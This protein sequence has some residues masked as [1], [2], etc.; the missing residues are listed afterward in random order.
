MRV[1]IA[2][3]ARCPRYG[4]ALVYGVTIGPSPF[5]LRYRLH[6]LGLRAISNVVDVTNYVLMLWGHPIH[7]FDYDRVRGSRIAV[8]LA[9]AGERMHTLDGSERVLTADDLLIC[10]GEGPVAIAGVMG[11]ANSEIGDDTRSAC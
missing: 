10:D 3:G 9:R 2:D 5:W 7:A 4:A 11:G 8:R 1:D 6:V